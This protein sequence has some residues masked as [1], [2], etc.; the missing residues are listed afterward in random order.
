M[1][2]DILS[3][4]IRHACLHILVSIPVILAAWAGLPS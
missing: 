2:K 1:D 4:I 3:L